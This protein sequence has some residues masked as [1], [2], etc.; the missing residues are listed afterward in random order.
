MYGL[1]K[2]LLNRNV[3]AARSS[4]GGVTG[5]IRRIFLCVAICMASVLAKTTTAGA[6]T[7][8]T[9][10]APV[11]LEA[12]WVAYSTSSASPYLFS[13]IVN[14]LY[15]NTWMMN[16]L[17]PNPIYS[18]SVTL[19]STGSYVVQIGDDIQTVYQST[20]SAGGIYLK[21]WQDAALYIQN[22]DYTT[23][24]SY[25]ALCSSPTWN[26]GNSTVD[27]DSTTCST[28]VSAIQSA[29]LAEETQDPPII[30]PPSFNKG[31]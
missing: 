13:V 2:R 1:E 9:S 24:G 5:V 18:P 25:Q 8:I 6:Y 28:V 14:P 29:I 21:G 4:S 19:T 12:Q 10:T 15:P 26:V 27:I 22:T 3:S 17:G 16:L 30:V 31:P 20:W 11:G 7:V 23:A